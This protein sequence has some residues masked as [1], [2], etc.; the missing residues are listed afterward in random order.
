LT[1]INAV[2]SAGDTLATR[3]QFHTRSLLRADSR[4]PR[5][6]HLQRRTL[7]ARDLRNQPVTM[8]SSMSDRSENGTRFWNSR[9]AWLLIMALAAVAPYLWLTHRAHILEVL[10]LMLPLLICV[11]MH[12]FM[13]RGH[14]GHRGHRAHDVRRG[15][16]R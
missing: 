4:L 15:P 12:L 9:P 3:Q 8:R 13:H 7:I 14:G 11:G 6:R 1:R 10:P 16:D 5:A 2:A